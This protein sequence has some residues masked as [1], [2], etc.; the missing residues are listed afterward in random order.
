M[1]YGWKDLDEPKHLPRRPKTLVEVYM[2]FCDRMDELR[3]A[4][5]KV[6]KNAEGQQ[7]FIWEVR[8]QVFDA[9]ILSMPPACESI[10]AL[11]SLTI[12]DLFFARLDHVH[13]SKFIDNVGPGTL[14]NW[15]E[16]VRLNMVGKQWNTAISVNDALDIVQ[17][18]LDTEI[19]QHQP[20]VHFFKGGTYTR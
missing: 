4:G 12:P 5:M 1:M 3:L 17:L 11:M 7:Y 19:V 8:S 20:V 16:A 6:P 2:R 9:L 14:A 10:G 13:A 15:D 18:R